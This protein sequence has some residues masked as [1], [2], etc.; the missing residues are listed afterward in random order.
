MK[1]IPATLVDPSKTKLYSDTQGRIVGSNFFSKGDNVRLRVF[2]IDESKG[3]ERVVFESASNKEKLNS[4]EE[5]VGAYLEVHATFQGNG[6]EPTP[7]KT[8]VMFHGKLR[9]VKAE[10]KPYTGQFVIASRKYSALDGLSIS[11]PIKWVNK[12]CYSGWFPSYSK[13]E[14]LVD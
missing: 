12:G 10:D 8:Q 4:K 9:T 14:K 11:A 13:F 1:I 5:T 6:F 2:V 7:S 3:N